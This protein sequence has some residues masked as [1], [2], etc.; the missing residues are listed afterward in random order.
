MI[1]AKELP[2]EFMLNALRLVE[3]FPAELF[4]ARSGLPLSLVESGLRTAEEK[5][6]IERNPRKIRPTDKGRHFLDDLVG[7]F[8]PSQE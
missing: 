5:G 8:L 2:F 6:L 4:A 1:E 3:G 7:L